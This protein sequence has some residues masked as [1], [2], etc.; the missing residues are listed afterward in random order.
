MSLP[1]PVASPIDQASL[2]ALLG[3]LLPPQQTVTV[4]LEV[5]P[6]SLL[7]APSSTPIP[8]TSP[9]PVSSDEEGKGS[10]FS[11]SSSIIGLTLFLVLAAFILILIFLRYYLNRRNRRRQGLEGSP[12]TTERPSSSSSSQPLPFR[13]RG[14]EDT[15]PVPAYTNRSKS[16]AEAHRSLM[17]AATRAVA[18]AQ[19][20]RILRHPNPSLSS[21]PPREE[22]QGLSGISRNPSSSSSDPPT[23]T[24]Y[25][26]VSPTPVVIPPPVASRSGWDPIV[27]PSP[28]PTRIV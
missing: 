17:R 16:V 4:T 26:T 21:T 6:S 20:N 12:N 8:T 3:T 22:V 28:S 11:S 18:T 27:S 10:A 15:D 2:S 24:R 5:T 14:I 13:T 1:T 19:A 23:Y 9:P 25:S 7:D